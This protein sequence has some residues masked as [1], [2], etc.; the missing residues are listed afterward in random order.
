MSDFE[1]QY[2]ICTNLEEF[3]FVFKTMKLLKIS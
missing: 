3:S 2:K 1:I